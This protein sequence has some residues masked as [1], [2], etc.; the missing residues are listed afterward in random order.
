MNRDTD[1]QTDEIKS[2]TTELFVDG[3]K[4]LLFTTVY[5]DIQLYGGL[6]AFCVCI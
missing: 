6:L 5:G 4:L 2:I 1:R 3:D